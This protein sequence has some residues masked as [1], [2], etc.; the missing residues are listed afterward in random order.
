MFTFLASINIT[1]LIMDHPVEVAVGVAVF[2]AL[3]V[4]L[5][6][7]HR[8]KR[9][10]YLALP[11][12][13]IGNKASKV[14]HIPSCNQIQNIGLMNVVQFR[15]SNEVIRAGYRPCNHCLK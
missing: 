7:R 11:V 14:Y 4:F 9:A 1:L 12:L 3:I 15:S 2:I 6:I 8:K 10:A 13:Y 5:V